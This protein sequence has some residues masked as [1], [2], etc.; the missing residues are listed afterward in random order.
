MLPSSRFPF[1]SVAG[2][3]PAKDTHSRLVLLVYGA[4][5]AAGI[6]NLNLA[7]VQEGGLNGRIPL[8]YR[9]KWYDIAFLDLNGEIVLIEIMRTYQKVGD[10]EGKF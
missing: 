9:G 8:V 5:R 6:R 2:D 4:L 3:G 1:L 10:V 7:H